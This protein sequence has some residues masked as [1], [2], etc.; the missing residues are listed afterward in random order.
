M[1]NGQTKMPIS[2]PTVNFTCSLKN[3]CAHVYCLW[4]VILTYYFYMG[5]FGLQTHIKMRD[6]IEVYNYEDTNSNLTSEKTDAK[7]MMVLLE[8]YFVTSLL[9]IRGT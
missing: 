6:L 4:T 5:L 2:N 9:K 8:T 1:K 7:I 3:H